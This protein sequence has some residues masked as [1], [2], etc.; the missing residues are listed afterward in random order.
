VMGHVYA[1]KTKLLDSAGGFTPIPLMV[2]FDAASED[3]A[4]SDHDAFDS[5]RSLFVTT[6]VAL[7]QSAVTTAVR[8]KAFASMT[9]ERPF[10]IVAAPGHDQGAI[11]LWEVT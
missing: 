10:T 11:V 1:H 8:G 6:S 4:L 7:A 2:L 3:D 9:I 5:L